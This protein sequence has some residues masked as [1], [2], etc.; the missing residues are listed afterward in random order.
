MKNGE[1]KT[2]AEF[3]A[4]FAKARLGDR[5]AIALLYE[6]Y[7][8]AILSAV[9]RGLSPELRRKYD[10]MDLAHSVFADVIRT[11]PRLEDRG[12]GAFVRLLTIKAQNKVKTKLRR[13]VGANGARREHRLAT[14]FDRA[15][16]PAEAAARAAVFDDDAKLRRL[17]AGLDDVSREVLRR[18]G[19]KEPF[20]RI[21]A[22]LQL[23]S[24]D[25]A[26]KKYARVIL[27]LRRR[28]DD[29]AP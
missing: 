7:G 25:A 18:R 21:A 19:D 23:P 17:I 8:T 10:S 28:W 9:R 22:D 5:D 2:R 6:R 15:A 27:E 3:P 14:H 4:L 16:P 11:L 29:P 1:A 12:E 20:A 24:A 13:H 26:R